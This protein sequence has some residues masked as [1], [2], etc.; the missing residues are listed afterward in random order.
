MTKAVNVRVLVLTL[1]LIFAGTIRAATITVNSNTDTIAVNGLTT[2]REAITSINAGA[3]VN[4]DVTLTRVG[5]Y[6][7]NDTINFN[8]LPAG[9]YLINVTG[10]SLPTITKPVTIDGTTQGSAVQ[11]SA[12]TGDNSTHAILLNCGAGCTD[13]LTL[14]AGSAG[15]TIRFLII[16]SAPGSGIVVNSANNTIAGNWIGLDSAGTG[17]SGPN[18]TGISIISNDSTQ[19][20]SGNTVG[21]P[22]PA[23]RNV[24]SGN[25]T[26]QLFILRINP[27]TGFGG[28]SNLLVENN[29]IGLRAAGTTAPS[30]GPLGGAGVY[31]EN[32][33]SITF[34]GASNSLGGSC[35]GVCNLVAGNSG[36]GLFINASGAYTIQGNFF[37]TDVTGTLSRPNGTAQGQIEFGGASSASGT[38]GGTAAG[39]G[40][41]ISGQGSSGPGITVNTAVAG[42][43]TIQGNYIGTT[44]TGNATLGNGGPGISVLTTSNVTIGGTTAAARNVIGGNGNGSSP[45][46]PGIRLTTTTGAIIQGNNIGVGADGSSNVGNI[47]DGIDLNSG[48]N[49][50]TIGASSS[51]GLGGNTIA[52]NG[53]GLTIGSG[54]S[55]QF[56]ST[57]NKILSNSIF[58]NAGT[59]SGIG[60]DLLAS[61][62]NDGPTANDPCDGDTGGNN[63]QNFPVLSSAQTNGASITIAGTLNSTASTNFTIEFFSNPAGT[64]QGKTFLGS[65]SVATN[66]ACTGAFNAVLAQSVGA[67]LNITATATD[68]SG[69]TSEFSAAVASTAPPVDLTIS[70]THAGNFTQGDTGK[71]YTITVTNNGANPSSGLVTMSD[72]LPAGLIARTLTGNGWT[73]DSI[74]AGG[75]AGPATLNCTRSDVLPATFA[76]PPITLTVDVSCSAAA[77][78]TNTATV[79]GGGDASPGNNTANDPTTV[80]PENTPPVIVCPGS[81]TKFVDSG[82][83]TAT[84]NPGTPVAT[85]NCGS[86]TVTG[87]RSDGKPLNAPYP[88]GLTLITWTAKDATNHTAS[89]TQSIVVMVPS[90]G[91]RIP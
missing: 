64:S 77:S 24:I 46:A 65:T 4:A 88:I 49:N 15:S 6:G 41:L 76:Y 72:S 87:V 17:A 79:S 30:P 32:L 74:P 90:G 55:V 80:N 84:V 52:N 7:T 19:D 9:T 62:S 14:G 66:G 51:G 58:G 10:S 59:I 44:T 61:S 71:S 12:V 27:G 57:G 2:L 8:I 5:A 22:N 26:R 1:F 13:G 21:G 3:D 11:N 23:D 53:S 35:A 60:I 33:G 20:I 36:Q 85:D 42:P 38:I 18:A 47:G 25:T 78:V 48:S 86:P 45:K 83:F 50:N 67:G 39:V 54:V 29:Y 69:N 70:K 43:V 34:G 40:N 37:G 68:P 31:L 73:C 91:R 56:N 28:G 63:F 89:C 82:Q 81:I 16:D 75:T